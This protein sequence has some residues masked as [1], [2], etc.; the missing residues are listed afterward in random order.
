VVLQLLGLGAAA[1]GTLGLGCFF[2]MLAFG[3]SV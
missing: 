1:A 2:L 3:V